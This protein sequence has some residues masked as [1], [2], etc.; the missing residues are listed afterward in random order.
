MVMAD[1]TRMVRKKVLAAEYF[2]LMRLRD[3][4]CTGVGAGICKDIMNASWDKGIR[5]LD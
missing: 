4:F 3:A 5:L 2:C 1:I